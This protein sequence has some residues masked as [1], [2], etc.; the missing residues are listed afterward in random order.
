MRLRIE[1]KEKKE[2]ELILKRREKVHTVVN[3]YVCQQSVG[4]MNFIQTG[5]ISIMIIMCMLFN[6]H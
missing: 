6:N 1:K 3:F 4:I 5:N 2:I